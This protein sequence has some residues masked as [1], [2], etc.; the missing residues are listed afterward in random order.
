M[1]LK[2][3]KCYAYRIGATLSKQSSKKCQDCPSRMEGIFCELEDASLDDLGAHK[4]TNLYKKGQTLFVEG[5]PPYGLYCISTGN[6]KV[7]KM[8]P[9]G[10][11]NIVRL[12]G[13][14]DVLGHRSIFTDQY[15]SA[16][17]TALE[18][19][20][21]CFIDKKYI[22]NKVEAEPTISK[23]IM[24]R[25]GRDL[26]ISE[27]KIASLSQKSVFERTAELLLLLGSSHSEETELGK[28]ITLKLTREEMAS[29]LG[30][31]S[32]TLIRCLSELKAEN[33]V[34]QEGKCLIILD[35]E[36]LVEFAKLNY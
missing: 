19:T 28:K 25:L 33:A 21:V 10:K 16:T 11:E 30:T 13:A 34:G 20:R 35:E 9:G 12:A 14:G 29:Y 1:F 24:F 3:Y 32:E 18:D 2:K 36:K 17:A 27:N 22:L 6:V 5:N 8:G 23:N 15:Y 31:S 7:S 4:I 26:G